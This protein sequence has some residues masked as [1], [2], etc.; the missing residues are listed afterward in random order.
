MELNPHNVLGERIIT[1]LPPHFT[2]I[3]LPVTNTWQSSDIIRRMKF[4]IYNNLDN[5]FYIS[6][7]ESGISTFDYQSDE[8]GITIGFED[9]AEA[10]FFSIA[11]HDEGENESN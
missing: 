10:T 4:W 9:P 1:L 3:I 11:Y 7:G 6:D 5:R 2:K 8:A